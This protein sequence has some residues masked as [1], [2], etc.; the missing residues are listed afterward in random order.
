M[1]R[2][3]KDVYMEVPIDLDNLSLHISSSLTP[4]QLIV[5]I[6]NLRDHYCELRVDEL[7]FLSQLKNM[8]NL[9]EEHGEF[10]GTKW[11]MLPAMAGLLNKV[12]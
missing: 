2:N 3:C 9:I 5:F 8:I 4:E 10:A 1:A 11:E 7:V 12:K 6:D